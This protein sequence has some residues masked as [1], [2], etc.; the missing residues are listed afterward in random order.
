MMLAA[1]VSAPR[2]VELRE[3][4]VPEPAADQIRLRVQ[5]CGVCG[6]DL[7]VWT[8]RPWFDYP[9]DPGAPGHEAWGVVDGVG[10][11][12]EG[13]TVGERVAA[14]SYRSY[15][16]FDLVDGDAAVKLPRAL[17]GIPFPGEPLACAVNVM[18]RSGISEEHT[19]AIVGVGF[20]GSLL[21]QLALARGADVIAVTRRPFALA[22]AREIG[23]TPLS[24]AQD[25]VVRDVARHTGGEMCDVVI[26]AAGV[27]GTL[28][29][30]SALVRVR[31]RLMIAGYH[32]DGVRTVNM[33]TWNWRGIDVVNAHE[34]E[35]A[36]YRE[37]LELAIAEVAAGN[38]DP[39]PLYT[40]SFGLDELD[41]AFAALE[42]RK[43]RFMKAL[44]RC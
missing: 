28:D 19:V 41:G 33:Q 35:P 44:I 43:D 5:G 36:T 8:G 2:R 22:L 29:L 17:D 30:A 27:Q 12:V 21:T 10:A 3:L 39:S 24:G 20:L 26:E 11:E 4:D 40:H 31:G 42:S 38:L 18:R 9:R 6:S 15:A 14:I 16:Q 25:Q 37:G 1:T 13:F 23:A 7:P 34:R 32:Q